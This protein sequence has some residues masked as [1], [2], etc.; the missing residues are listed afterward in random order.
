M[1]FTLRK[2]FPLIIAGLGVLYGLWPIDAIPDVP[3]I[4]WIDDL[5]IT[6]T[7]LYFAL[8]IYLKNR[9]SKN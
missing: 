5:G 8:R 2:I 1:R 4:G 7:L 6:G 9:R 3:I